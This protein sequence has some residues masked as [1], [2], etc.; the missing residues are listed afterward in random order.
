MENPVKEQVKK[1]P[2]RP[3]VYIY[4][5]ASGEVIYVG[6]AKS[7]RKRVQNYFHS[8]R[9][10]P[11][12]VRYLIDEIASL[13]FIITGSEMEA[14]ILECNL[15]KKHRPKYNIN[16]KDDKKYPFIA[17]TINDSYPRVFFTRKIV[18]DGPLYFGPFTSARAVRRTIKSIQ[19]LFPIRNCKGPRP[20]KSAS[21]P[22]LN[23][24]LERCLA[25]CVGE[26]REEEYR[27]MI[28]QVILFLKGRH[29]DLIQHFERR[30]WDYSR[31]EDFEKAARVRDQITALK[32]MIEEQKISLDE[33]MDLDIIASAHKEEIACIELFS[34]R[35]GKMVARD[36]FLLEGVKGVEERVYL[37]SFLKLHYQ[38][39]PFVP[40]EI[41]VSTDIEDRE[42]IEQWLTQERGSRVRVS[43]PLKGE[44]K[45]LMEMAAE[46]AYYDLDFLAEK[47]RTEKESESGV[48]VELKE[49]LD[50][51]RFPR[52]IEGYDIS[53]IMGQSSVGSMVVFEEGRSKKSD[54]KRFRIKTVDGQDDYAMLAEVIGR[55]FG[56]WLDQT[57]LWDSSFK[58][59]PDLIVVDGGKGQL[60][61]SR[62]R[63]MEMSLEN[64]P[65]IGLAKRMEEIYKVD[66]DR[67]LS[68]PPDSEALKL[69]QRVRDEAHRF[70]LSY[71]RKLRDADTIR[72]ILDEIPGL[73][74]K[75]KQLLVD[76]FGSFQEVVEATL[77][78]LY[79]VKGIPRAVA[80]S[81]FR[82]FHRF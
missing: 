16:L 70:A 80:E 82:H 54:Y 56:R 78:E 17:I 23:F 72:S 41:L 21:T 34:T 33:E 44:K 24:H 37:S 43:V 45:R 14:L 26:V 39:T 79:A 61:V 9:A 63:L 52:R 38:E 62:K 67:S 25:P 3:G 7:L 29:Q 4:R 36:H 5:N 46:N 11:F 30:M 66:E 60:S 35:G 74:E 18:R 55:R 73:G 76:H 8:P 71:H 81:I 40:Q 48:L 50:L 59:I 19:T 22:C 77:E 6:K 15:I 65:I 75:R 58:K 12:N 42:L 1:I 20:G 28:D 13:E 47:R 69:L 31:Q 57:S 27:R 32:H 53:T 51:P 68:L 49:I 10:L 64:L 2:N